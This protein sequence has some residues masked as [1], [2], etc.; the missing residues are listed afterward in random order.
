MLSHR[1]VWDAIDAI[2][3]RNGLSTS[4]LARVA[5]LDPTAFNKS[6]RISKDGRERWPSTESIAKVL[7]ATGENFDQFIAG[8]GAY[9]QMPSSPRPMV[10]L[11]GLARAGSGGFFDSAGLPTG[12]GW[13]EVP[14][15]VEGTYAIEVSGDSMEPLYREGDVVLVMPAA[16]L[17]R[18]D[19]V[20]VRTREGEALIKVLARQTERQVELHSVNPSYPPRI[21]DMK[22]IEGIARI[23]WASQ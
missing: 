17:R 6:K 20:V 3:Q 13:D 21:I 5:G 12:Q 15:G 4:K 19:R 9:L 1:A 18:G 2:A 22:D 23:V 14:I 11:L 8:G 10:P 16:Q 7:E